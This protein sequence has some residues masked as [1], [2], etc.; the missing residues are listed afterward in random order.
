MMRVI[1]H[2]DQHV[3][4]RNRKTG[5]REP[6]ITVKTYNSNRR[7]NEVWINGPCKVVYTPDKPLKC[8]SHVYLIADSG[9]VEIKS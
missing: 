7:A 8:G 1:L 4:K 2:I 9:D 5:E 3:I 6:P